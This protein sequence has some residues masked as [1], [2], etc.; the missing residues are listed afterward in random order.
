MIDDNSMLAIIILLIVVLSFLLFSNDDSNNNSSTPGSSTPLNNGA[1]LLIIG[2]S[3]DLEIGSSTSII[4]YFSA[5]IP[6]FQPIHTKN[7]PGLKRY[8]CEDTL[9]HLDHDFCKFNEPPI[10]YTINQN[11]ET[12]D[13]HDPRNLI[14]HCYD[15]TSSP[16]TI[17]NDCEEYDLFQSK[18][19]FV[20]TF[21]EWMVSYY[22]TMKH[23]KYDLDT[24]RAQLHDMSATDL[25]KWLLENVPA[26][27]GYADY[28]QA[29]ELFFGFNSNAHYYFYW[30]SMA[31]LNDNFNIEVCIS[32]H[33]NQSGIPQECLQTITK[34]P[35]M[36]TLIDFFNEQLNKKATVIN[37]PE[38][39]N[40]S[41]GPDTKY[42]KILL[43]FL[44]YPIG[45]LCLFLA[46]CAVCEGIEVPQL[47]TQSVDDTFFNLLKSTAVHDMY[48]T[49]KNN[50]CLN[51]NSRDETPQ[52]TSSA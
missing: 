9:I 4:E 49:F 51:A 21:N 7:D 33:W 40:V 36:Y 52:S 24:K 17:H 30:T 25:D 3:G 35:Y 19:F 46:G 39:M 10:F 14:N 48:E 32:E 45:Q 23:V 42:S 27:D 15:T 37:V 20:D 5:D 28:N 22:E 12:I 38:Q 34:T 1:S 11:A 43:N 50:P 31:Q 2:E 44:N 26:D 8:L 47:T 41:H 16:P 29:L 6:R 18:Q 13:M